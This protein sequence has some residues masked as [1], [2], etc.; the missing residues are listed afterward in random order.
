MVTRKKS[1]VSAEGTPDKVITLQNAAFVKEDSSDIFGH[2]KASSIKAEAES[3]M[4]V[5]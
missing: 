5:C 4:R 3:C 1:S 2:L